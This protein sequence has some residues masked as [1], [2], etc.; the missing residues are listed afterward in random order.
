MVGPVPNIPDS[1]IRYRHLGLCLLAGKELVT[2]AWVL[3]F[4]YPLSGTLPVLQVGATS[5]I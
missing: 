3:S 1:S 4:L 5:T 2:L